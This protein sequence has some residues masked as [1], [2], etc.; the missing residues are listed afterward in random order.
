[1]EYFDDAWYKCRTG[2]D[3]VLR[4]R[5]TTL[6]GLGGH[7]FFFSKK[8]FLVFYKIISDTSPVQ[9]AENGDEIIMWVVI[10]L[11]CCILGIAL[12]TFQYLWYV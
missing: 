12:A 6:V 4:T 9:K 11:V 5:M 8:S 10:C 1:M 3:D 2:R 7:L